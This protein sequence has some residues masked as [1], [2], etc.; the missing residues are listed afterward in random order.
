MHA[1]EMQM[2]LRLSCS[3]RDLDDTDVASLFGLL[4]YISRSAVKARGGE[5]ITIGTMTY[6]R[7]NPDDV[8][9]L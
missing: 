7:K 3:L 4:G 9:W 8:T 5:T 2:M 1:L 6:R